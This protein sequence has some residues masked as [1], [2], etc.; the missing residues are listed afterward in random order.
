M[1]LVSNSSEDSNFDFTK[2]VKMEAMASEPL[3]FFDVDSSGT[4]FLLPEPP[5]R[6]TVSRPSMPQSLWEGAVA[7]SDNSFGFEKAALSSILPAVQASVIEDPRWLAVAV[8]NVSPSPPSEKPSGDLID[9]EADNVSSI[10]ALSEEPLEEFMGEDF[11]SRPPTPPLISAT[12]PNGQAVSGMDDSDA[13]SYDGD[14]SSV[15][16]ELAQRPLTTAPDSLPA[17]AARA[18]DLP[19]SFPGVVRPAARP[20]TP[21]T[22]PALSTPAPRPPLALGG[23]SSR[24]ASPDERPGERLSNPALVAE[25]WSSRAGGPPSALGLEKFDLVDAA[26]L[27]GTS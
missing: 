25:P 3:A 24:P 7:T 11:L 10:S 12:R 26:A 19:D 18:G 6:E 2:G 13:S 17:A 23:R 16:L 8:G 4:F 1:D 22:G 20:S 15:L 27:Y 21:E 5:L 14:T 9:D